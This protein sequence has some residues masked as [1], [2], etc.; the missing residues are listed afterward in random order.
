MSLQIHIAEC[1]LTIYLRNR[2]TKVIC[3]RI[4]SEIYRVRLYI[5]QSN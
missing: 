1:I 4:G 2:D 5:K 3:T